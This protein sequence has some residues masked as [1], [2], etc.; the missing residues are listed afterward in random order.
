MICARRPTPTGEP[1]RPELR[2][3]MF[4][5]IVA[6]ALPKPW[7]TVLAAFH[8]RAAC[9]RTQRRAVV[10]GVDE[11]RGARTDFRQWLR[12]R[13]SRRDKKAVNNQKCKQVPIS[14]TKRNQSTLANQFG[15][16][17][18][19]EVSEVC[20]C[21]TSG[22]RTVVRFMQPRRRS[23]SNGKR[24]STPPASLENSDCLLCRGA[25]QRVAPD[26]FA[27]LSRGKLARGTWC[28]LRVVGQWWGSAWPWCSCAPCWSV[29]PE[30]RGRLTLPIE[31]TLPKS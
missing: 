9:G 28:L 7:R 5:T 14:M 19:A 20:R 6:A 15:S 23:R 31:K 22:N 10:A 26:Q 30:S 4:Q 12:L 1:C 18:N 25:L 27:A 11:T 21:C 17:G 3:S 24:D 8:N 2:S 13:R 16:S 29:P